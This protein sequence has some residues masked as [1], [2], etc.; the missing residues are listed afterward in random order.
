[1]C[2]ALVPE[3]DVAGIPLAILEGVE[4][5]GGAEAVPVVTVRPQRG[6]DVKGNLRAV[7]VGGPHHPNHRPEGPMV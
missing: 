1:M 4:T 3:P 5:P 2:G 7:R 6:L